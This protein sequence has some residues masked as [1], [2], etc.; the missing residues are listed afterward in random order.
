MIIKIKFKILSGLA[1]IFLLASCGGGGGTG[2]GTYPL[3]TSPG[4]ISLTSTSCGFAS[5]PL[6]TIY[7]GVEPY[8]LKNPLPKSIGLSKE[9]VDSSGD[10]FKID[11]IGGCFTTLPILILDS[12][13]NSIEFEVTYTNTSLR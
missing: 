7:G 13:G 11:F 5:G 1:L 9:Q 3:A 4:S 2:D 8:Y 6:V 12:N 10:N